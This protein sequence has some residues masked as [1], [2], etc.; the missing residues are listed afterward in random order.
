[1]L[2]ANAGKNSTGSQNVFIGSS[3]GFNEAASS[4]LYIENSNSTS[5]LIYGE[6]DNDVVK[7]NAKVTIRDF[8]A[9]E[10]QS[11]TLSSGGT[12]SVNKSNILVSSGSAI[13]LSSSNPVTNGTVV[14]QVL[15]ITG[16]SDTN[17]ITFP[18]SGNLQIGTAATLGLNDCLTLLWSGTKWIKV[19]Y[20]N[21]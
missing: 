7:L 5:P 2:G 1:M 6:F 12:L 20:S 10:Q 4:R 19:S 3:A 8:Y 18:N 13:T 15:I 17:T 14:G 16:T 21:N 9:L 11:S